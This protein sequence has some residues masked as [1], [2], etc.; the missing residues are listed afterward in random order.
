MM[1]HS[2]LPTTPN[3]HHAYKF[4]PHTYPASTTG[5]SYCIWESDQTTQI[6]AEICDCIHEVSSDMFIITSFKDLI[7]SQNKICKEKLENSFERLYT[8]LM[9]NEQLV[10]E[11]NYV[12]TVLYEIF[13]AL[14]KILPSAL[15]RMSKFKYFIQKI[16]KQGFI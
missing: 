4:P 5:S 7:P 3:H 9:N 13:G 12:C 6:L 16:K 10:L 8:L 1:P 2:K 14:E 15:S 11:N